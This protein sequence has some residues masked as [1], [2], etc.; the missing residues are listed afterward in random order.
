[1]VAA[2]WAF[3][4]WSI[5]QFCEVFPPPAP[6]PPKVSRVKE[7]QLE[8]AREAKRHLY[9]HLRGSHSETMPWTFAQELS[10]LS[11]HKF[12]T[13]VAHMKSTKQVEVL[14]GKDP[15]LR[16]T[17]RFFDDMGYKS[18]AMPGAWSV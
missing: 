1:M 5:Q 4:E 2:A 7:R 17:P 9:N 13:V 16:F 14:G 10:F 8:E 3:V 12:R 18:S 6:K 11:V 15:I